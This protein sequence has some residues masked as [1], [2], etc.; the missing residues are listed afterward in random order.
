MSLF[1]FH[2]IREVGTV[3]LELLHS[4]VVVTTEFQYISNISIHYTYMYV[5]QG[6]VAMARPA[7]L[8]PAKR[9]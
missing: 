5:H 6:L 4:F 1:R 3:R 7:N 8:Y 9:T 2:N